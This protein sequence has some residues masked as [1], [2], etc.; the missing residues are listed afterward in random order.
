MRCKGTTFSAQ[1][2]LVY[3]HYCSVSLQKP[4]EMTTKLMYT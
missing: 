4:L 2:G 1:R 3:L